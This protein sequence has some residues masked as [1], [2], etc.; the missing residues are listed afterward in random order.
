MQINI[1]L[2]R[3]G[4][5]FFNPQTEKHCTSTFLH[6]QIEPQFFLQLQNCSSDAGSNNV[7]SSRV[8]FYITQPHSCNFKSFPNRL[9]I[10]WY[11]QLISCR[12]VAYVDGCDNKCTSLLGHIDPLHMWKVVNTVLT[13]KYSALLK[14][15]V[16]LF[17]RIFLEG[18]LLTEQILEVNDVNLLKST[19]VSHPLK[20][21]EIK[22]LLEGAY[23][24]KSF[25]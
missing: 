18:N 4:L 15:H 9:W 19:D 11:T 24:S 20:T 8:L 10:W 21:C 16:L 3:Y 23:L 14:S 5:L 6:P 25:F 22:Y 7:V 17:Q 2:R 13:W 1:P 12:A